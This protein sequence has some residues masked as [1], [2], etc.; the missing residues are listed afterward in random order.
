[1]NL[2]LVEEVRVQLHAFYVSTEPDLMR[3][4]RRSPYGPVLRE[5]FVR[6]FPMLVYKN[7]VQHI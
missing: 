7:L 1:M 2:A 4:G 5:C 6:V 3:I